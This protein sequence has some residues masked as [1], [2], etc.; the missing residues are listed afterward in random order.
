MAIP[1][2][3]HF[4]GRIVR[5]LKMP[6]LCNM[7]YTWAIYALRHKC[8]IEMSWFRSQCLCVVTFVNYVNGSWDGHCLTSC[9]IQCHWT[10][11]IKSVVGD[12]NKS[13]VHLYANIVF[14]DL[15]LFY[16]FSSIMFSHLY[17]YS[18]FCPFET[19]KHYLMNSFYNVCFEGG[20]N[21]SHRI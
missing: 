17:V 3:S 18:N 6:T 13:C 16:E 14:R 10:S 4:Y 11:K 7:T 8:M 12:K 20:S 21:Y 2:I 19:Q 1:T 9:C 15:F 5:M